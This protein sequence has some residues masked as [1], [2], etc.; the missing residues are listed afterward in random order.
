MSDWRPSASL[1]TIRARAQLLAEI[2]KFFADRCVLE[3]ETP[4]LAPY[5]V[6]EPN[7]E[8]FSVDYHDKTFFLQT[9]PEYAMKRL[10]AAGSGPIY[11]ICKSFRQEEA[12]IHHNPEFSMLEWY[13]PGFTHLD[14]IEE[15][16][17]LFSLLLKKQ[18]ENTRVHTYAELFINY[19]GFNTQECDLEQVHQAISKSE[20][21]ID[22]NQIA[23]IDTGLNLLMSLCIE[24][25]FSTNTLIIIKDYP[26][27]QAALAKIS[28]DNPKVAC[29]FEIFFNGLELANG[30]YE[31]QDANIQ[32]IRFERDNLL[33]QNRQQDTRE[34][35]SNLLAALESGLPDCSGVA[36]GLDRVLMCQQ[37][38]N[39]IKNVIN[40]PFVN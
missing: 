21:N 27:S 24:P 30:F 4:L 8:S 23:D 16:V 33:R 22:L 20:I 29:R 14:L 1:D 34:I 15:C 7:I 17:E 9:S 3:V 37:E 38:I 39:N 18:I 28:L 10:L 2:R 31:L 35:D 40:F 11:Q 19:L 12:G 36:V 26:A 5:T 32:K 13:R 6:T 25:K